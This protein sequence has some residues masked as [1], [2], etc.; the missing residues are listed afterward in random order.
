MKLIFAIP[1]KFNGTNVAREE[2][3]K[4]EKT[5]GITEQA[6][7]LFSLSFFF[8]PASRTVVRI[9]RME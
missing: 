3:R 5:G 1:I 8:Y 2:K 7:F 4:K 9:S 6:V